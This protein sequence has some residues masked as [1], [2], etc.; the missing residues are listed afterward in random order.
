MLAAQVVTVRAVMVPA[1]RLEREPVEQAVPVREAS[2]A[3]FLA[4]SSAWSFRTDSAIE[5][6][7]W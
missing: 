2:Q 6:D 1:E 7:R 5:A 3:P 4:A